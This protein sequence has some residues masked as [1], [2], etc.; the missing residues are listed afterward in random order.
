MANT[1]QG[2]DVQSLMFGERGVEVSFI[3]PDGFDQESG[4]LQI[5]TMQVPFDLIEEEMGELMDAIQDI[6][7]AAQV[8][9]RNPPKTFTRRRPVEAEDE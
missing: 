4:I 7:D 8:A 3:D 6:L 9:R 2:V 1:E 5:K